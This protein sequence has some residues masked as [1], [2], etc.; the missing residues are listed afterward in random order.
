MQD[1]PQ[2]ADLLQAARETLSQSVLPHQ[3]GAQ[4][5]AVL[6]IANA[7]GMVERELARRELLHAADQAVEAAG[8]AAA[9]RA[10][11]CDADGDLHA[12]LQRR[13]IVAVAISRPDFL[14]STER[15]GIGTTGSD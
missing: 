13:T 10:G 15:Q 3:Q 9:I 7:L 2:G 4:R 1:E 5:F 6:M 14:T 11:R 8:T 12:A